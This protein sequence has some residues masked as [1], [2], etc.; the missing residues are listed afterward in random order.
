MKTCPECLK[1]KPLEAFHKSKKGKG[2]RTARCAA[3]RNAASKAWRAANPDTAR[4]SVDAWRL[5]NADYYREMKRLADKRR[6][7][8]TADARLAWRKANREKVAADLAHWKSENREVVRDYERRRRAAIR[9]SRVKQVNLSAVWA[10][11]GGFCG[12][13]EEP[14]DR[15]IPWPERLSVSLDHIVPLSRGGE[16]S[17]EN[18]RYVHL[19]CNLSKNNRLDC[20]IKTSAVSR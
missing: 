6:A 20:E 7:V 12:L 13:C 18:V 1:T 3:C 8:E 14:L 11:G 2:G 5:R 9:G 15:N 10:S 17:T 19:G 4:A 16:H